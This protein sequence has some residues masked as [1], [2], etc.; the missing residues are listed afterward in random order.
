VQ[1]TDRDASGP[2]DA[3]CAAGV[4]EPK[5]VVLPAVVM[6]FLENGLTRGREEQP[7]CQAITE[8]DGAIASVVSVSIVGN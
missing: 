7:P 4:V 3:Y 1:S 8:A 6:A 2:S 5:G